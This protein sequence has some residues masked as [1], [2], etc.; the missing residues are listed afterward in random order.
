MQL[1]F[2]FT[3]D[4]GNKLRFNIKAA[5]ITKLFFSKC[6]LI[7][8]F[9]ISCPSLQIG[10]FNFH[11]IAATIELIAAELLNMFALED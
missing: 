10:F 1:T 5:I 2:G 7:L 11:V 8:P 6:R 4:H 3:W 9:K